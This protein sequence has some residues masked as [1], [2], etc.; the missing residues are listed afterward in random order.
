MIPFMNIVAWRKVCR[1]SRLLCA[2]FILCSYTAYAT[3]TLTLRRHFPEERVRVRETMNFVVEYLAEDER[4]I[5]DVI[6]RAGAARNTL[7]SVMGE[8]LLVRVR[9]VVAPTRELFVTMVGRWAENSVAVAAVR[10]AEPTVILNAEAIRRG[11]PANFQAILLHEFVHIYLGLRCIRPLPQWFEEGLATL[12]AGEWDTEDAAAV[13]WA[14]FIGGLIPI[15][16]LEHSFPVDAAVQQL[17]YRQSAS[18]VQF[19]MTQRQQSFA[20]FVSNYTGEKGLP[21]IAQLWNPLYRDPLEI[22]WRKELR[23][24]RNWALLSFH[25]GLFWAF[26]AA[27]TVTAWLVKYGRNRARRREWEEEEKIYQALDEEEKSSASRYADPEEDE[28]NEPRP[29]WYA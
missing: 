11:T 26:V 17:A 7:R 6:S 27:L 29:P 21:E 16:Q 8:A 14:A 12:A 18:L 2:V 13:T 4:W 10:G 9:M 15:R 23:S 22:S 19:M 20:R 25:S 5:D 1:V 24:F 3:T 28:D